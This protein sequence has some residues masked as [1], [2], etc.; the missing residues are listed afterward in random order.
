[1]SNLAR[2]RLC[3]A[4]VFG[5]A[6]M[7]TA[8]PVAACPKLL[9]TDEGPFF[10]EN[11]RIPTTPDL[12][13]KS[14]GGPVAYGEI[15]YIGGMVFGPE[16]Q[17]LDDATVTIW[18]AD[19]NGRYKHA[20]HRSGRLDARFRYFATVRSHAGQY[21]F[22]TIRPESYR[23]EGLHRA[24]HVHFE[25]SHRQF[26]RLTTE[27]YFDGKEDDARRQTDEVWLSRDPLLR[28]RLIGR[29]LNRNDRRSLGLS[30]P[31]DDRPAY[32]YDLRLGC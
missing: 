31:S 30:F 7:L 4:G 12:T 29:S 19:S 13:R 22:T 15:I 10:P 11:A 2:R 26:G 28:S 23:F 9:A 14:Q 6:L 16:C 3:L 1:M 32:R 20:S 17:L 25:V 24:R 27:M 18:Q 21:R 8:R 5:S